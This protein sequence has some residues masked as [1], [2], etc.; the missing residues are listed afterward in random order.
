MRADRLLSILLLLQAHGRMSAG[1]LADRLEVSRR[2]VYRDLDSLS[3]AGIPVV[4]DRGPTG[5]AYLLGGFRTD[6]TGL[7]EAELEVLLTF[8]GQ[9]PAAELG[10]RPE[11]EQA[12]RK[13]AA[14]AGQN[15]G[16]RLQERVV[17]D[18]ERWWRSAPVPTHLARVQDALWSDRRLRLRYRRAVDRVVDR[19]VEPLGLISKAGTWYLLAT[20]GGQR[21][22]YRVSRIEG[23]E[24]LDETFERPAGFDLRGAWAAQVSSFGTATAQQVTVRVDPEVAEPFTRILGERLVERR[25]EGVAVLEFP[26]CDAA[27]GLLA[28]FAAAVEV[29]DPPDLRRRL[30]QIG[31]QLASLYGG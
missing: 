2:T 8:G 5:G 1:A 15:R 3:S 9:G 7:T 10:L 29:L 28:G 17:I 26:T 31:E 4:T 20:V 21:R 11:L 13:L 16:G 25:E 30:A 19:T 24:M 6:L 23:A 14:A 22:V 18:G 12:S 27:V